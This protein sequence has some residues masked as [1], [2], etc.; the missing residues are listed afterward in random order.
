MCVWRVGR[1]RQL[2]FTQLRC[3][4]Y[5]GQSIA[6]RNAASSRGCCTEVFHR[7]LQHRVLKVGSQ[8][9]GGVRT[10]SDI[11]GLYFDVGNNSVTT[12]GTATW[13]IEFGGCEAE[14]ELCSVHPEN[15]LHA[16]LAVTRF[17]KLPRRFSCCFSGKSTWFRKPY[18][19]STRLREKP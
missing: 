1:I 19:G 10:C 4:Q 3:S 18:D 12:D 11:T 17:A 9:A 15:T 2:I 8:F 7:P 6:I 14:T 16:S 5:P 13:G